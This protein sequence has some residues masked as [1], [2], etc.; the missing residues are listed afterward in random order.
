[1]GCDTISRILRS[2]RLSYSNVVATLALFVALGGTSYAVATLP[3][4][5]VG[6][7]QVRDG[8]LRA[9]DLA[10]GVR[11]GASGVRGPRGAQG[12]PGAA[13]PRGPADVVVRQRDGEAFV[14][15]GA[16][17]SVDVATLQL[18]A[19]QWL[20]RAQ[21]E[22]TFFPNVSPS[23][24]WFHCGL[25]VDGA[26]GVAQADFMGNATGAAHT[27]LFAPSRAVSSTNSA[28]IVLHCSHDG[29]LASGSSVPSFAHT[30][31]TAIRTDA[32][33]VQSVTG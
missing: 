26:P 12:P 10:P 27:A 13:G 21:T 28:T 4:N 29:A 20:V 23:A 15:F 7:A 25:T 3:R 30:L 22:G 5:S 14:G 6:S 19:G 9:A 32:L 2:P 17:S 31:L 8:S 1:V 24:D 11:G 33:D 16:G 18:P